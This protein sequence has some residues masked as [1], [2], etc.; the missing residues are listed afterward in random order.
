VPRNVEIKARVR[1]LP[2]TRR[3]VEAIA[4][5]PPALLIQSDSFF[6]VPR[7]R[8]KLRAFADGTAELISYL[9]HD[10]SGPRESHFAKAAVSDPDALAAV[11]SG[12]LGAADVVRK[13][14]TLYRRGPTRIH[15][16]EVEDLGDFLELEVELAD[17]QSA[18]DGER[19]ARE[20]M[21]V[22]GIAKDDLVAVAYVDLLRDRRSKNEE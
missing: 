20:L 21:G 19:T 15:L 16:D 8:L 3:A 4:D 11:L 9:R 17:G 1:D 12:A 13:R 22:L 7:G 14:R 10:V 5:G 6:E 18:E 2:A